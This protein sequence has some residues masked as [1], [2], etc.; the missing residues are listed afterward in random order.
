MVETRSEILYA[1]RSDHRPRASRNFI[2]FMATEKQIAANR[3]NSKRSTGPKTKTGRLKSSRNAFRHGLSGP[4]PTNPADIDAIART[5]AVDGAR[6]DTTWELAQTEWELLRIRRARGQM[7][8]SLLRCCEPTD[9]K[10]LAALERYERRARAK[11]QRAERCWLARA[12]K[13]SGFDKTKPICRNLSSCPPLPISGAAP[14]VAD[15]DGRQ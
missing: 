7:M 8:A 12:I 4:S 9:I 5:L 3:A 6:A 2:A 15:F 10:R 1:A 13:Q 14:I 11:R